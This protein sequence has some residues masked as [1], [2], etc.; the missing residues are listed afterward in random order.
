MIL[1]QRGSTC[2]I[3]ALLNGLY[4]EHNLALEAAA[5]D[6]V[7][8]ELIRRTSYVSHANTFET[9]LGEFFSCE[10]LANYLN[11]YQMELA[12]AL[13]LPTY[14][15]HIVPVTQLWAKPNG[16]YIVP[17][18][19]QRKWYE[20]Q[21]NAAL[22]W[23]TAMP[24][25]RVLNSADASVQQMTR[26]ELEAFHGRLDERHFSWPRW[27]RQNSDYLHDE[28]VTV[29]TSREMRALE[30]SIEAFTCDVSFTCGDILYV[31]S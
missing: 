12:T 10:A 26:A 30:R 25:G 13:N 17:G 24:D 16:F 21:R 8:S 23:M 22:H 28:A 20:R 3:Y 2:G 1:E 6:E 4:V 18:I 19:R 11:H 9:L 15:V 29:P 7:I 31:S 14:T 5:V 27:R